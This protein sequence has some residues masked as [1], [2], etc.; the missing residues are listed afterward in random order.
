MKPGHNIPMKNIMSVAEFFTKY[1]LNEDRALAKF[2]EWRWKDGSP[3]C[4]YYT[5]QEVKIKA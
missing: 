1:A 3:V 5:S 4:P 2:A